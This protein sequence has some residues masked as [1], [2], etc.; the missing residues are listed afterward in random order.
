[1]QT[2]KEYL[3]QTN[4]EHVLLAPINIFYQLMSADNTTAI[5]NID[6][7]HKS[8]IADLEGNWTVIRDEALKLIKDMSPIKGEQFFGPTV[9]R[10]DLW[11]KMYRK[12]YSDFDPVAVEKC[13]KT[14][15]IIRKH[16]DIHLAMFSLL[17]KGGRIHK[18]AG[19]FRGCIR[20]HL[21]LDT[22]NSDDCYI[23]IGPS[24]YS[25]R[26]GHLVALDDTYRHEVFN[27]TNKDRLILFMDLERKMSSKWAT[28]F[29]QLL[30]KYIAPLTTRA[31]AKLEKVVK[32]VTD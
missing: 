19:P 8:L 26:D 22:P 11:K 1:M 24:R 17:E 27:N 7:E 30:I 2:I 23:N 21:G 16:A 25:W 6:V 5:L 13:P 20:L 15:N 14:V 3:S 12:W 10:N 31:N 4:F 9:I 32:S 28:K 29:N 18:H